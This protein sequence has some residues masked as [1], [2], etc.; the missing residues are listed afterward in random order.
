MKT[1]AYDDQEQ[2]RTRLTPI[3]RSKSLGFCPV[4][5]AAYAAKKF[6]GFGAK[7]ENMFAYMQKWCKIKVW[8]LISN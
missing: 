2:R 3:G 6:T 7:K 4:E 8:L 5:R 1:K